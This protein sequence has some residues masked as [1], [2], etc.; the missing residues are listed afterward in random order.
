M[1]EYNFPYLDYA[2]E[3]ELSGK[4]EKEFF[5]EI[6]QENALVN[7]A[8]V[9]IWQVHGPWRFP[10]HDE[11]PE[12]RAERMEVMKRSIQATG[13]IGCRYWVIHPIMPF[14]W[15]DDF[16][17]PQFYEINYSFF[18]KLLPTAKKEGVTICLENM[19]M[20]KLPISTP[21]KTAEFVRYIHDEH[22]KLCLDTGH[23]MIFGIQPA[24]AL[25]QVREE[26]R[27]LHVHDNMGN[28]DDHLTPGMGIG[29]WIA[30]R[31]ELLKIGFEGVYSLETGWKNFLPNLS[32]NTKIKALRAILQEIVPADS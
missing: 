5:D 15:N 24:D 20:K 29:D 28:N 27:V 31:D 2:I 9:T 25:R 13:M 11:T 22:F 32:I 14:G 12:L 4:T 10:P 23:A 1:Q 30:F 7:Q 16:D 26:V 21:E 6:R 17:T 3:G 8:G 18:H 19:P